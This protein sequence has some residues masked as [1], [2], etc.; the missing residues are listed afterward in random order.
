MPVTWNEETHAYESGGRSYGHRDV[1]GWVEKAVAAASVLLAAI[2]KQAL[3]GDITPDEFEIEFGQVV[4][5]LQISSTVM[6]AGGEDQLS[7]A[8][9]YSLE[10]RLEYHLERA[11]AFTQDIA[12][13]QAADEA[14]AEAVA[15]GQEIP[16][17]EAI[18][19]GEA[20]ARAEM[21]A[22]AGIGSYENDVRQREAEGELF[23]EECRIREDDERSCDDCIEADVDNAGWKPIGELPDIGDV[24]CMVNDRCTFDYR[25]SS[26]GAAENE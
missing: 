25:Q 1:R 15:A 19:E 9:T 17:I 23:D 2:V 24:E 7:E 12:Q 8:L 22:N 10:E 21:Y 11:E 6:A 18:S 3:D 26:A 4:K 16:E 14:V 20:F 5:N 13:A